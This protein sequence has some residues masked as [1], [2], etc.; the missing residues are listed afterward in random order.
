MGFVMGEVYVNVNI[1]SVF[2]YRIYVYCAAPMAGAQK[3]QSGQG[4]C[5]V[6]YTVPLAAKE[7]MSTLTAEI[8]LPVGGEKQDSDHICKAANCF[9]GAVLK[10]LSY[11]RYRFFA[12]AVI[13]GGIISGGLV[14][15]APVSAGEQRAI[16][17][18]HWLRPDVPPIGISKGPLAGKG[19]HGGIVKVLSGRPPEQSNFESH[20]NVGRLFL[21]MQSDNHCVPGM[22]K[23]EERA[24]H[25]HFSEHPTAILDSSHLIYARNNQKLRASIT[26]DVSLA[27]LMEQGFVVG[28]GAGVSFGG[29]IDEII[30][31]YVEKGNVVAL[32]M[33]NFVGPILSMVEMGRVD[34]FL[35]PPWIVTW[36]FVEQGLNS[37]DDPAHGILTHPF[38]EA[39]TKMHYFAACTKNAWG[40]QIVTMI[41]QLLER[42]EVEKALQ[43]NVQ[44]WMSVPNA[45]EHFMD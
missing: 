14:I 8:L 42:P 15:G 27:D 33:A 4:K 38:R 20:A 10:N 24:E 18:V 6:V 26:D 5:D 16:D 44:A 11:L 21:Q 1:K 32:P 19:L 37:H 22:V 2:Q 25:V 30:A 9:Y 31:P 34:F 7:N 45:R 41:D 36:R 35:A 29:G 28:V 43:Q 17:D 3:L 23:T 40:Q 12:A 13:L 39:S